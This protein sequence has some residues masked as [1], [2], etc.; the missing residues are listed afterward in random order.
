MKMKLWKK[1]FHLILNASSI[2]QH[3]VQNKNGIIKHIN[4][5]LKVIVNATK[6]IVGILADIFVRIASISK[7]LLILQWSRVKKI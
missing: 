3:I 7:V 4:V 6:I 1:G 2:K 5:N